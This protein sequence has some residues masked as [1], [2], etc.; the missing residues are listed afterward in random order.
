MRMSAGSDA[1]TLIEKIVRLR[2]RES[3]YWNEHCFGLTSEKLID[4]AVDL[5]CF[6][7]RPP[8]A[9]PRRTR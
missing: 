9:A 7:K 6:G 2:I 3:R 4:K 5:R 8:P 1:Q